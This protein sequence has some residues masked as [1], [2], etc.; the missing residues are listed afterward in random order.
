[1]LPVSDISQAELML[2]R[3]KKSGYAVDRY[4]EL[5]AMI[6]EVASRCGDVKIVRVERLPNASGECSEVPA[7]LKAGGVAL[8]S[9]VLL[10]K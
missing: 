5:V 4:A 9:T 7:V 6:R 1:V 3:A 8:R 2:N 10:C